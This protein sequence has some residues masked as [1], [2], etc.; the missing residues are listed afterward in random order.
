M[1][2]TEDDRTKKHDPQTEKKPVP[3]LPDAVPPDKE[4]ALVRPSALQLY[5]SRVRQYSLLTPEEEHAL[6]VKYY[7]EGDRDAAYRLVTSNLRLVFKIALEFQR[8][9]REAKATTRGELP[10]AIRNRSAKT[11]RGSDGT[12]CANIVA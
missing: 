7:E 10:G 9:C 5:L 3:Q 4:T 2:A 8:S 6:A 1:P 12:A 11:A